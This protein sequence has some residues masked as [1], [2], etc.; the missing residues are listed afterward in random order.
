MDIQ[1]HGGDAQS[2]NVFAV[3][4]RA[5]AGYLLESHVH[6]HSHMSVLVSGVAD[7]TID[8]KTERMNGYRLLTVPA[9]THHCVRAVTDVVW[10]CLWADRL[11]PKEQAKESLKLVPHHG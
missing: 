2:G 7:V 8:G 9:N 10:L 5:E 1:F 3:E 4:T 6:A 11:A